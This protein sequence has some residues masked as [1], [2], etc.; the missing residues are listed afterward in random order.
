MI[1]LRFSLILLSSLNSFVSFTSLVGVLDNVLLLKLTHA[2]DLV[3]VDNETFVITMKWLDAL[4]AEDRQV[5]RAVEVLDTLWV[6]ITEL[7]TESFFILIFKVKGGLVKDRILL[8]DFV[9]NVDVQRE[10]LGAFKL[11]DQFSANRA[12]HSILVVQLLDAACAESMSAVN[13]YA[14]NTFTDVVL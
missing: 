5:I 11:L 8:N 12:S 10:S 6:L 1:S 14:W 4:S 7:F 13:Q 2:L 9:E 3:Q